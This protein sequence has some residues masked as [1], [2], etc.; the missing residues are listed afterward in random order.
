M[1]ITT[2]VLLTSLVA[3]MASA[4]VAR[5]QSVI[6]AVVLPEGG[7]VAR[8]IVVALDAS[9][10]TVGRTLTTDRGTFVLRLS[11][12]GSVR[13]RI[14]RIGFQPSEGPQIEVGAQGTE[15]VRVIAGTRPVSL[16]V[17][18]VHERETCRVSADTG[19]LVAR[20]WEE[21]RTFASVRART[22]ASGSPRCPLAS[23][24][25]S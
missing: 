24:C 11:A 7:P 25:S 8:A 12:P 2:R 20:V 15:R 6:G 16:A 19:L 21:A 4:T 5:A 1:H 18:S 13:L 9:G 17:M 3:L 14:L 22:A 10:A 23:T